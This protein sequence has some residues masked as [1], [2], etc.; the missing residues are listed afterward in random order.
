MWSKRSGKEAPRK[1][2]KGQEDKPPKI[3]IAI[4]WEIRED[5][6]F[7]KQGLEIKM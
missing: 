4:L 5:I 3:L 6:A 7:M 1:Q 2:G